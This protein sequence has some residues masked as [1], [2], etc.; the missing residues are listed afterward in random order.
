MNRPLGITL[1]RAYGL[2]LGLELGR[3]VAP[4]IV[5]NR[6]IIN[7]MPYNYNNII[8]VC[9]RNNIIRGEPYIPNNY[10]VKICG[11]QYTVSL[12]LNG[13]K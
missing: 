10:A 1:A 5:R 9:N 8:I 6:N 7:Y 2:G 4:Y 13:R 12:E 11:T 3:I